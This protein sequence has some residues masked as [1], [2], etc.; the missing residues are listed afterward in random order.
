[1]GRKRRSVIGMGAETG[2]SVASISM[3]QS[4][5]DQREV[6][7]MDAEDLLYIETQ[8]SILA[9]IVGS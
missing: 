1:M 2:R 6:I 4:R 9:C 5:Q 8:N 3:P 7:L